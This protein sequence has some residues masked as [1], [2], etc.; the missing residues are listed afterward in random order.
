MVLRIIRRHSE[1][2]SSNDLRGDA[3]LPA[4]E[5]DN[6]QIQIPEPF[7]VSVQY[8]EQLILIVLEKWRV[9]IGRLYGVLALSNPR[10][11]IVDADVCD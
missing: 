11:L 5:L 4:E 9:I 3:Y 2:R 10:G 7:R 1:V 6:L 8:G